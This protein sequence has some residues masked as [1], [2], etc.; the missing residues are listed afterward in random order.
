MPV[1]IAAAI[2][3]DKK[4]FEAFIEKHQPYAKVAG[5]K[6]GK[7]VAGLSSWAPEVLPAKSRGR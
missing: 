5:T 2:P 1:A 6:Y 3:D 4:F 7:A